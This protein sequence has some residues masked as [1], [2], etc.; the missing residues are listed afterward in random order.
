MESC[1]RNCFPPDEKAAPTM[2]IAAAAALLAALTASEALAQS[3]TQPHKA[4]PA[5]TQKAQPKKAPVPKAPPPPSLEQLAAGGEADAQYK[6]AQSLRDGSGMKK[7]TAE[8]AYWFA[9]A[10]ANGVK[11]A[12]ADLARLYEQGGELKRDLAKAALWWF[13]AA[14]QGDEEAKAH[15]LAMVL[16][17]EAQDVGGATGIAWLEELAATGRTEAMQALGNAYEHGLGIPEDEDKARHWYQ[18]AA[19]AGDAEAKFRLGQM[20][21]AEPGAW[22]LIYKEPEREAKNTERGKYYPTKAA[23]E[24]VGGEERT[25]DPVRPGMVEAENWLR[26]AA[27]QGHA[28]AQYTLGMAFLNGMELPF[29]LF[30]ALHWL[31]AAAY[32]GHGDALLQLA[33]LA[34]K[35]QGFGAKDPVRA[36]VGYDLAAAQGLK[37]AEDARERVAKTMNP[38][39]LARARQVAQ[40]L[41][42]N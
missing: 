21:L 33:D 39:Q 29:N 3:P 9:L 2:R 24:Q 5:K 14:E 36:W 26:D 35:G 18:Q 23:A 28:E 22:R 6:L 31:S 11:G 30:E 41:R 8:A 15:F 37:P 12:A 32:N 38:K 7:D 42:G 10:S 1:R 13:R 16:D 34:E 25:A 4:P 40:D 20:L 17:G 27:R 19:F